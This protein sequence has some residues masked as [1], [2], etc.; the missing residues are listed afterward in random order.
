M[1]HC[2]IIIYDLRAPGRDYSSL[3]EAIKSYGTWGKISES[4]WAVVTTENSISIRDFL[5]SYVDANDR[6]MVIKS[7][8]EAAWNNAIAKNDWLQIN[9]V[10]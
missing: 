4:S 1:Y 9:L 2:Y 10:K 3:Y 5:L 7:G 6:L 8:Q